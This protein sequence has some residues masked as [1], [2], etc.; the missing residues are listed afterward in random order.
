MEEEIPCD[1]SG[2]IWLKP[3]CG[4]GSHLVFSSLPKVTHIFF[5]TN[6]QS[7]YDYNVCIIGI[8]HQGF[9]SLFHCMLGMKENMCVFLFMTTW[10]YCI[11]VYCTRI[12]SASVSASSWLH[13]AVIKRQTHIFSFMLSVQWNK[14]TNVGDFWQRR[15]DEMDPNPQGLDQRKHMVSSSSLVVTLSHQISLPGSHG[16]C[17][18]RSQTHLQNSVNAPLQLR[19]V[20]CKLWRDLW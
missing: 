13:D 4:L 18:M 19:I 3:P 8:D 5:K 17:V 20:T 7:G 6:N 2:P 1:F 14:D 9:V 12:L 15:E 11:Q 10:G 16:T